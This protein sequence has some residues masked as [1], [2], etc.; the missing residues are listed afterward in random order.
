VGAFNPVRLTIA[1]KRQ[2][3]SSKALADKIGSSPV[4]VSRWENGYH[5]PE[6][7]TLDAL[8]KALEFPREFFVGGDC[9]ELKTEAASFRSLTSMT[10][11]ERDAA[12]SAGALAYLLSD[13][14]AQR[15]NLPEPALP[16]L[17]FVADPEA[18]AH[19]VRQQWGIGQMPISNMVKLLESKGVRVFSLAENNRNVDAFS[20]WRDS[21]P[22][23]FLNTFKSTEHS[24]FDAAH[25]LGHLVLHK[26]GGPQQGDGDPNTED[27]G[28]QNARLAEAEANRFA[29]CFLMPTEDVASRVRGVTGLDELVRAKKRWGVSVAALAYRLNKMGRLTEWQYR[30]FCIEMNRRGYR[31]QEPETLP[32]ERS[33]VWQKVLGTLWN[34]RITKE[35]IANELCLPVSELE[36]LLFGLTGAPDPALRPDKPMLHLVENSI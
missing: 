10:A 5:E 8:A 2:R 32:P 13:W 16:D 20:C 34:E 35:N 3:L 31:T 18:A 25:E 14:V 27:G 1:R 15:F 12:L 30:G 26:H 29:S 24:R 7:N 11:K 6:G 36:N 4:T 33:V 22:Y 17:S 28:I 21:I 19:T 9:E 23:I